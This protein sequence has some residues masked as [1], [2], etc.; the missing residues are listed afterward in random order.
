MPQPCQCAFDGPHRGFHVATFEGQLTQLSFN[1][2][3]GLVV[4]GE[5]PSFF[6]P[7]RG[8]VVPAAQHQNIAQS[9]G[10]LISNRSVGK[11]SALSN[12]VLLLGTFKSMLCPRQLSRGERILQRPLTLAR[13]VEVVGQF[14]N[15]VG[16]FR[17][18]VERRIQ[19]Q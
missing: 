6:G 16:S 8:L 5:L 15:P 14:E 4:F 12:P 17:L 9:F 13:R 18:Q 7:L 10:N 3:F 2:S 1:L 19:M 11:G